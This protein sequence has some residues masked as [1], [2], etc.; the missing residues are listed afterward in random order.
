MRAHTLISAG[1]VLAFTLGCANSEGP[2]GLPA[3]SGP[4][5]LSVGPGTTPLF[6]WTPSCRAGLLVVDPNSDFVAAWSVKTV[7]DTNGLQPPIGYGESPS[8]S[9]TLVRAGGPLQVG[10]QYRVRVYRATGD[11]AYLFEAIGGTFFRP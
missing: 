9:T 1:L 5:T 11:T 7:G 10:T 4:V 3:C 8:G 2:Q 6:S